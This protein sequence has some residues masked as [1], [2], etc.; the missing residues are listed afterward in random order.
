[1]LLLI[2]LLFSTFVIFSFLFNGP[3]CPSYKPLTLLYSFAVDFI[4]YVIALFPLGLFKFAPV[5]CSSTAL[6]GY[7][8]NL[9]DLPL[10][11]PFRGET[12]FWILYC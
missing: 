9:I 2:L 12:D 4:A 1:M 6:I 10:M 7:F 5:H 11:I 3:T 8:L